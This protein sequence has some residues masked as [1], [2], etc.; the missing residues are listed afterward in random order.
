[1]PPSSVE[2]DMR[3]AS[4]PSSASTDAPTACAARATILVWI[5]RIPGARRLS[6]AETIPSALMESK[7]MKQGT[8]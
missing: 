2:K 8:A 5:P 7:A 1:M 3:S 6:S 4:R